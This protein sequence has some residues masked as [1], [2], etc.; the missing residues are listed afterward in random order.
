MYS[1]LKYELRIKLDNY[2]NASFYENPEITSRMI[3]GEPLIDHAN[4]EYIALVVSVENV[5]SYGKKSR[6]NRW[7]IKKLIR[8]IDLAFYRII[9]HYE[10]LNE[11]FPY[12]RYNELKT[13]EILR[14]HAILSS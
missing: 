4:N 13:N 11:M 7:K 2:M 9:G 10:W 12:L 1:E 6:K 5:L 14:H 3:T 8:E